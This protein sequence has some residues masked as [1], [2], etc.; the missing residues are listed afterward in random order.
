VSPRLPADVRRL[1]LRVRLAAAIERLPEPQRLVLALRLLDG[2]T[3]VE[4]A[5][6]LKLSAR[7]V[8]SRLSTAL[9]SIADDVGA[10]VRRAA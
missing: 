4:A 8:E 10:G 5:G 3:T 2:L 6:T 9:A 7:E 1:P